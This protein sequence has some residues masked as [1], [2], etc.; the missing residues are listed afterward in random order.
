VGLKEVAFSDR[1]YGLFDVIDDRPKS[2]TFL[3]SKQSCF[4][5]VI[6]KPNG[7]ES[8]KWHVLKTKIALLSCRIVVCPWTGLFLF[9]GSMTF[10]LELDRGILNVLN[11]NW[12]KQGRC[13]PSSVV[14]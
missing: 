2:V 13:S 6:V 5:C 11:D 14:M 1:N 9:D 8:S 7:D 3:R 12:L 4:E 10:Q